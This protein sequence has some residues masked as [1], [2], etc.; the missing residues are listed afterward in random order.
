MEILTAFFSICAWKTLSSQGK[1]KG[2]MPG[3]RWALGADL[4]EYGNDQQ[5]ILSSTPSQGVALI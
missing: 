5:T 4:W 1:D 2:R 3:S